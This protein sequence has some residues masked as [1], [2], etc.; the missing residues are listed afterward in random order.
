MLGPAV[1]VPSPRAEG[2]TRLGR[3]NNPSGYGYSVWQWIVLEKLGI[4]MGA[5]PGDRNA[6]FALEVMAEVCPA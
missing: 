2:V 1:S 6:R 5:G 3:N 4:E